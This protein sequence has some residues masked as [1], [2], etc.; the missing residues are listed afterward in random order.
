MHDGTT[1][2]DGTGT[3]WHP[4]Q[5]RGCRTDVTSEGTSGVMD[6]MPLQAQGASVSPAAQGTCPG[7][8]CHAP[9]WDSS[10]HIVFHQAQNRVSWSLTWGGCCSQTVSWSE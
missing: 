10:V 3:Q 7:S 1:S 8:E 5:R 2:G 4:R 6:P 9:C